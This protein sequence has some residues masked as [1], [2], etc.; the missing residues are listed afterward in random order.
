MDE[1]V[2]VWVLVRKGAFL[3]LLVWAAYTWFTRVLPTC[4]YFIN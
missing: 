4:S 2:T 1:R 3:A